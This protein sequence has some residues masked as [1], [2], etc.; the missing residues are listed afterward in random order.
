MLLSVV[1]ILSRKITEEAKDK[2]IKTP[3]KKDTISGVLFV[4]GKGGRKN[5]RII[6]GSREE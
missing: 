4:C 6:G 1:R 2:N 5:R 3:H